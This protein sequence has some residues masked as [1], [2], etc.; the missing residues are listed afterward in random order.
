M[1]N[2]LYKVAYSMALQTRLQ[3]QA[4]LKSAG[5]WGSIRDAGSTLFNG[6]KELLAWE[7]LPT[8][9]LAAAAGV[10][11]GYAL[12]RLSRHSDPGIADSG[13]REDIRRVE[14][15]KKIKYYNSLANQLESDKLLMNNQKGK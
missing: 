13:S 10:G 9:L 1:K 2:Q 15:L 11:G 3:K 8:L 4:L 5:I 14:R 7:Y 6:G 12:N